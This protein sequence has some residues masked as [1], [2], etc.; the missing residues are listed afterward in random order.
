MKQKEKDSYLLHFSQNHIPL[1]TNPVLVKLRVLQNV[2]QNIQSVGHILVQD[3]G[4]IRSLF[5]G[6]VRIQMTTH[7]LDLLLQL[8]RRP[9]LRSLEDH[10]LEEMSS[11]VSLLGLEPRP[12]ID[13][14]SNRRSPSGKVR[15]G[16]HP[17]AI[18]ESSNASFRRGE[19][20]GVV[21]DSRVRRAVF[22]E[23]RVGIFELF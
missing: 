20:P 21:S 2:S 5:P 18:G 16:G 8:P 14:H 11:S 17:E 23:S 1:T 12:G 6:R 7:V 15:L 19:N 10:M 13:P 3:L 9:F 22:Q 4:I